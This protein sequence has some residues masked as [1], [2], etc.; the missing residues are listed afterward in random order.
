[1]VNPTR[2]SAPT[3]PRY[4][5]FGRDKAFLD[6]IGHQGNDFQITGAFWRELNAL[7]EF[8]A[9]GK[10]VCI[11]GYEWSANTAVGGDRNVHY[12]HEGETIHRSSHALIWD[13]ADT[14]DGCRRP[15][16]A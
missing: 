12:R 10:F 7:T 14:S 1:M 3:R 2:R 11:P 15:Y 8:D 5:E 6:I 4:F 9:A 13:G 16:C